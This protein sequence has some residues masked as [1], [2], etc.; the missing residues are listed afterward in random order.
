MYLGVNYDIQSTWCLSKIF[1]WIEITFESILD[2]LPVHN[3][4][5]VP[6]S[7]NKDKLESA[8]INWQSSCALPNKLNTSL[9]FAH[10]HAILCKGH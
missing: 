3:G 6:C 10:Q 7:D 5:F 4:V 8:F 9:L 2:H 1:A